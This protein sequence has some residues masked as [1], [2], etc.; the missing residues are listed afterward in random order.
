MN[1]LRDSVR[2]G[3]PPPMLLLLFLLFDVGSSWPTLSYLDE[4]IR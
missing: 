4:I 2:K 1:G 3:L